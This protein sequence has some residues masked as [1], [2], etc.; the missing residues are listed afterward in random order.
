MQMEAKEDGWTETDSRDFL[1]LAEIAVPSCG[2][3]IETARCFIAI[4]GSWC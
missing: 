2:K 3:K 4:L 1:D